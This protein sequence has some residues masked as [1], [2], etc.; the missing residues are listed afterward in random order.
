MLATGNS[1]TWP[2]HLFVLLQ[3]TFSSTTGQG[4]GLHQARQFAAPSYGSNTKI[5]PY[6]KNNKNYSQLD[7]KK[8]D[9]EERRKKKGTAGTPIYGQI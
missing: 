9:D 8:G 4:D 3:W 6:Q 5:M 1:H 2:P 7:G